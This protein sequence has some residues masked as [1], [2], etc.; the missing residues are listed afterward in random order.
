MIL[1]VEEKGGGDVLSSFS[2]YPVRGYI[3]MVQDC[4]RGCSDVTIHFFIESVVKH[5]HRLSR[6]PSMS[7]F[8]RHLGNTV[9]DML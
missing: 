8:K 9:N 3:G 1:S 6:A 2:S 5:W 7:V 4:L